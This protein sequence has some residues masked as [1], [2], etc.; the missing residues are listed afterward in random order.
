MAAGAAAL[1]ALSRNARAQTY[2]AR[3]VRVVVPFPAGGP[4]D[5]LARLMGQWLSERL[6][7]QFVIDNRPGA[8][9]HDAAECWP[10][11]IRPLAHHQFKEACENG[12]KRET[13]HERFSGRQK[14]PELIKMVLSF[15]QKKAVVG[16]GGEPKPPSQNAKDDPPSVCCSSV[17]V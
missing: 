8:G 7:Q 13:E 15:D 17:A 1:P 12:R 4:A 11:K 9:V 6:G 2:P 3:P 10:W 14:I 5:I 16:N